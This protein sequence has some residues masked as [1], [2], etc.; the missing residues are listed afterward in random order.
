MSLDIEFYYTTNEPLTLNL[1][2]GLHTAAGLAAFNLRVSPSSFTIVSGVWVHATSDQIHQSPFHFPIFVGSLNYSLDAEDVGWYKKGLRLLKVSV[3]MVTSRV[4]GCWSR[5]R[6]R[7]NRNCGIFRAP[8]KSQA[9]QGTSLF[10]SAIMM[11]LQ[12]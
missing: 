7:S 10:A 12:H 1:F 4:N 6:L 11:N 8:L 5:S 3:A 9:H 2:V